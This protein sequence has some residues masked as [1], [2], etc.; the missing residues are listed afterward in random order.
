MVSTYHFI[1]PDKCNEN[2]PS[3]HSKS[4]V[5]GLASWW[6]AWNRDVG[7]IIALKTLEMLKYQTTAFHDY[8]AEA[9]IEYDHR[10]RQLAAKDETIEWDK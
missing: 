2:H 5:S 9:C 6:E 1:I 4:A 8:P 10:F 7:V 3:K